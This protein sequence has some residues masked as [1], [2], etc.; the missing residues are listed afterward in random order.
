MT[1]STLEKFLKENFKALNNAELASETGYTEIEIHTALKKL[2]LS[3]KI[4]GV[5]A[6]PGR[7]RKVESLSISN[8]R[9]KESDLYAKALEEYG[10]ALELMR[11]EDFK[12]AL[13]ILEGI[14]STVRSEMELNDRVSAYIRVCERNLR[15]KDVA[16]LKTFKDF[17][18]DGLLKNG[19]NRCEEAIASLEKALK[20]ASDDEEK[21]KVRFVMAAAYSKQEIL[22]KAV[23]NL[24]K[25]VM[26]D[27]GYIY[28]AVNDSD[29]KALKS[30]E[31]FESLLKERD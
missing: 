30:N 28:Q 10:K 1:K 31:E 25:A 29:F 6:L 21:G 22:D 27:R 12:K 20:K 19:N 18:Y 24:S 5:G 11:K 3:E 2:N 15:K 26:I 16:T 17:F 8:E 23:E 9:G 13:S 7:S 4:K 14:N